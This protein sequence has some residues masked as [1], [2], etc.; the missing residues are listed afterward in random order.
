MLNHTRMPRKVPLTPRQIELSTL[1]G[2]LVLQGKEDTDEYEQL[3][4]E[5][6]KISLEQKYNYS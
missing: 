4:Y 3:A 5:F 1:M 2:R 6:D